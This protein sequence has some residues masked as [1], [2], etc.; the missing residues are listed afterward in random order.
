MGGVKAGEKPGEN[1]KKQS[2]SQEAPNPPGLARSFS[3]LSRLKNE[4]AAP[5]RLDRAALSAHYNNFRA[6]S[7][8]VET[9]PLSVL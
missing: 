7:A 1:W 6:I 9:G 5:P 3:L 2:D 4:K 8:G